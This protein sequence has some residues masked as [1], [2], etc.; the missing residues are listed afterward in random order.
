MKPSPSRRNECIPSFKK[1]YEWK[2]RFTSHFF[3]KNKHFYVCFYASLIWFNLI[4]FIHLTKPTLYCIQNLSVLQPFLRF[5][6]DDIS[7]MLRETWSTSLGQDLQRVAGFPA[8]EGSTHHGEGQGPSPAAAPLHR[9]HPAVRPPAASAGEVRPNSHF[10]HLGCG[11][12]LMCLTH[13]TNWSVTLVHVIIRGVILIF[14]WYSI[15]STLN[16]VL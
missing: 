4:H 10:K 1:I 3:H 9:H 7:S 5:P 14:I 2:L 8:A 6:S 16:R 12:L 11:V 15:G 13:F